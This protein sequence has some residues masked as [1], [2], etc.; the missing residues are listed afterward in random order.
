MASQE[1]D[2][3]HLDLLDGV[4]DEG[5]LQVFHGSLHPVVEGRSPLGVLQVQLV[6]GFQQFLCPLEAPS[7]VGYLTAIFRVT[8]TYIKISLASPKGVPV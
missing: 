3:A 2:I 6:N 8:P 4:Y 7:R 1:G 5:V